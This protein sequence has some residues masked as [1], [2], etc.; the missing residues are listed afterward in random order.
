M[1]ES[2]ARTTQSLSE[3][4]LKRGPPMVLGKALIP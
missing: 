3:S 1:D 4:H 2:D